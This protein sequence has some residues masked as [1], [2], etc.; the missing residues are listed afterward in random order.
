MVDSYQS[1][2][3]NNHKNM[4]NPVKQIDFQILTLKNATSAIET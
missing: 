3:F 1:S 4:A 2:A